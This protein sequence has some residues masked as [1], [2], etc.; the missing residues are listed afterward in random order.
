MT[1]CY[2]NAV[3]GNAESAGGEQKKG[4]GEMEIGV[5]TSQDRQFIDSSE[6]EQAL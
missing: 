6:E 2:G 3:I 1:I 5:S 4:Q